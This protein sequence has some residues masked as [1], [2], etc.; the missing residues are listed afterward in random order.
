LGKT[1]G[2]RRGGATHAV[3]RRGRGGTNG[4]IGGGGV[5]EEYQGPDGC[6]YQKRPAGASVQGGGK[7]ALTELGGIAGD[8]KRTDK[9]V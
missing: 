5:V 6:G 3:G 4:G 8:G 1:W 7:W 2:S 9:K